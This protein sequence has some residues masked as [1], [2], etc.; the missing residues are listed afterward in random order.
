MKL[1][2]IQV[3]RALAAISVAVHHVVKFP[4]G[5]AGVDLF[6]VISGFIIASVAPGDTATAFLA[7]RVARIYPLYLICQ[8]PFFIQALVDSRLT[9]SLAFTSLTL[10]PVGGV[11]RP[12]LGVGWTLMF[13]IAFY[14]AAAASLSLRDYRP[15]LG[16][17]VVCFLLN[18]FIRT[19][20]V[21]GFVGHPLVLEF[22]CGVALVRVPRSPSLGFKAFIGAASIIVFAW[23]VELPWGWVYAGSANALYRLFFW[24]IPAML[25]VHSALS[26]E[27][28]FKI[29]WWKP[30]VILGDASY[31]LYLTFSMVVL[32]GL[33]WPI[34]ILLAVILAL[35][36]HFLIEKPLVASTMKLFSRLVV[37]SRPQSNPSIEQIELSQGKA[38][39]A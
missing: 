29:S 19:S 36:V 13:E 3:L 35:S 4:L 33:W 27:E 31:A 20:E 34:T 12:A 1:R 7:K 9:G 30:A 2:S 38:G 18:N 15:V 8:A 14:A 21:L 39:Q 32:L 11:S 16:G 22:L 6:F 28:W 23:G 26:F 24:G 10:I 5:A 25:F 17:F 37:L